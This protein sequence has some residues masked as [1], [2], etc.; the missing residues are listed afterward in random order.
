[1]QS[2]K[3]GGLARAFRPFRHFGLSPNVHGQV[4]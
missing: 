2:L 4:L 3:I 1:M